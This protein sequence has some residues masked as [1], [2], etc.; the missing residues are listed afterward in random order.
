MV[1]GG[2]RTGD[3]V[4]FNIYFFPFPLQFEM[5]KTYHAVCAFGTLDIDTATAATRV[6]GAREH[7]ES[8]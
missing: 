3:I 8:C 6:I 4:R 2:S 1:D 5:L 7:D